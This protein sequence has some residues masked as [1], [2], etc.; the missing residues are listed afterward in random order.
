[1][2]PHPSDFSGLAQAPG[3]LRWVTEI[4]ACWQPPFEKEMCLKISL[5]RSGDCFTCTFYNALS[6]RAYNK[7]LMIIQGR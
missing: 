7:A 6:T 2:D 3:Q 4:Y 5:A 1:M